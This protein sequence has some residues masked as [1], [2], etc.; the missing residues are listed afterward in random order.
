MKIGIV[1]AGQLDIDLDPSMDYIGVD[2]GLESLLN[3]NIEP[4]IIVGDFVT[5]S[6]IKTLLKLIKISNYLQ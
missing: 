4:K 6:I 1:G 3:Q 2:G 5:H